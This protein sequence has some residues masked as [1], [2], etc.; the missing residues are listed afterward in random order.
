MTQVAQPFP[1]DPMNACDI[2]RI[3]NYEFIYNT[4]HPFGDEEDDDSY[5]S[6]QYLLGISFYDSDYNYYLLAATIKP[7]TYFSYQFDSIVDYL[8]N[9]SILFQD[10]LALPEILQLHIDDNS[11]YQVIVK[12]FWLRLVQRTWKNVVKRRRQIISR[13]GG[14]TLRYLR[15]R[16]LGKS[17]ERMPTLRG[18]L[19]PLKQ[20]QRNKNE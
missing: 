14:N 11:V 16:E 18:M 6:G 17:S 20:Q 5:L 4:E 1:S 12:T 3:Q 2:A 15:N 19:N 7:R 9:Y 10:R 13:H 8:N